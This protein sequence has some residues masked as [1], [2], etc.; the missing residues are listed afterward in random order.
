MLSK[1]KTDKTALYSLF[2]D[3]MVGDHGSRS[4]FV[5]VVF[6]LFWFLLFFLGGWIW[7]LMS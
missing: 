6:I 1:H 2:R 4:V 7:L 5:V 3:R